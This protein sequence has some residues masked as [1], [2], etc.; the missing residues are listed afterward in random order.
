MQESNKVIVEDKREMLVETCKLLACMGMGIDTETLSD[1]VYNISKRII[2][3]KYFVPVNIGAVNHI[4]ANNITILKFKGDSIDP[5]RVRQ[6]V[7]NAM[8]ALLESF[9]KLFYI[10]GK[11]I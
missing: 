9:V 4:V 7:R 10:L 2:E 8:F 5:K 6:A 11:I 3:E 1:T